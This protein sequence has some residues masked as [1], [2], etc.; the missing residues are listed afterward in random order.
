MLAD[1]GTD[2]VVANTD[3]T[4]GVGGIIGKTIEADIVRQFITGNKLESDR[5]VFFDEF[6]HTAL[7][8][9]F[10]LTRRLMIEIKAH[11]ALL[12]LDMGIIGTLTAKD[13]YHCLIQKMLRRMTWRVFFFIVVV[14]DIVFC[15][16]ESH[17][18]FEGNGTEGFEVDGNIAVTIQLA[19]DL[20]A[21]EQVDGCHI[22]PLLQLQ[23][24]ESVSRDGDI[25]RGG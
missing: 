13:A 21:A 14:Q 8:L 1:A 9:L 11:L 3:E 23:V 5:Q 7:N 15:H 4:D 2:I 24:V 25:H 20:L 12:T 19:L 10:L 18:E 16:R 17:F 6:V 22:L